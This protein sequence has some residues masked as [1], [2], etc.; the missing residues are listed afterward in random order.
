MLV[1]SR[2]TA[3]IRGAA[4]M[5]AGIR[6]FVNH[7]RFESQLSVAKSVHDSA[8]S[9]KSL[10]TERGMSGLYTMSFLRQCGRCFSALLFLMLSGAAAYSSTVDCTN[11]PGDAD[12]IQAAVNAGGAVTISGACALQST[13][14][15]IGKSVTITGSAQLNS[16]G[17]FAFVIWANDVSISGL[18]FN[19]AGLHLIESPQQ[20]GFAFT[21]NKIQNTNGN[22]GIVVDGIL[23]ASNISSNTFSSIAPNGFASAT[24]TS[25]GFGGC[26]SH[27][28][29]DAPGVAIQIFGGIDQTTI[30]NNLFD[31][32]ANDAMHI[33][34]NIIAGV[35]SYFLTANNDISY[36]KFSRVHRIAIEAQAIWSWPYCG[37]NGSEACDMSRNFSTG[38]KVK[39]NYYHDPFLAYAETYAYSLA[40]WGDNIY[41]NNA[42]IDNS[43]N[44]QT[45]GYG[46]EDMGNN[47]LTQGNLIAADYLLDSNMHNWSAGIIY[48]AQ[49]PGT[50][51][52][53][54][55][56][57][58]CGSSATTT[59]FGTE[60]NSGGTK[61]NTNNYISN[62]CPN[63]GNLTASALTLTFISADS[64][65]TNGTWEV[66]A[67][68]TLPIKYVQFFIDGSANPFAT[69]EIQDVN[70]TFAT[71]RRWL[72]HATVDT[73]SLTFGSHTIV[74][75]ATDVAGITQSV[76]HIFAGGSG[77]T[78]SLQTNSNS[79]SFGSQTIGLPTAAK[80]LSLSNGGT[81][82]L[83]ISGISVVGL[84]SADFA[85][86][87]SCGA[88]LGAGAVCSV[89]TVFTPSTLGLES[90]Y[91]SISDNSSGAPHTIALNGTG[92]GPE[93][94]SPPPPSP[95][96]PTDLPKGQ[97][98][99]L[100]NDA[101]VMTVGS[102][103][104]LW[105]D[106]SGN[107]ND[108]AQTN[109]ANQPHVVPGNN[110]LTALHFDGKTSFM[111]I[112]S[113]PIA[114]LTGMTVF[115]VSASTE[116]KLDAGYGSY[117]LLSW[118]ETASWG[119]TFFGSYETSSHFRFGTTQ[120]GNENTFRMPFSRTQ[121]FGLSEWMHTTGSDSM[122]FNALSVASYS[123]KW[124]TISG[125]TS[126]A[127][128]GSDQ[129]TYYCGDVSEIIV[130]KR[131]LSNTERQMVER[132]LMKKYHL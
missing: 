121:S 14:I 13:V 72:Y 95:S 37:A 119:E 132:Y 125:V 15:S 124:Q 49:Q 59:N 44:G 34:W 100:A 88:A 54:Q 77:N 90:A 46:I 129:K 107:G 80:T 2:I 60:P 106:Q 33:G 117:A 110:G 86:T 57:V 73:S 108:A 53:T 65:V 40:I 115:V 10:T 74:A 42:A 111:S 70:T 104:S 112:A 128:L 45:P 82:Y 51:F 79:L 30:D 24:Y 43:V 69:Q 91:L 130:Y 31:L 12:S 38:T 55:N 96:L 123:G 98:L 25:L 56:N 47:V 92:I 11:A 48:G 78:P 89:D 58:I 64:S 28:G 62:A 41:I 99:W 36:N 67:V 18:T 7:L 35:S 8:I 105:R 17:S 81:G 120:S 19:G 50:E 75:K 32:I 102:S 16:T 131:S 85:L 113:L 71:D 84:N 4:A 126:S 61:V 23:R 114:G 83:T 118:P 109:V 87:S 1:A 5:S 66:A 127:V 27:G 101:R 52:K 29:C 63:A 22:D 68:S 94:V 9:S 97:I 116:D 39:G 20:T 26:Y 21:S 76:S 3:F 122:W 103:V 6:L 93:V